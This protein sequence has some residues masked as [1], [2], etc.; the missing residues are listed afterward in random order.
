VTNCTKKATL[1]NHYA[2]IDE[3]EL[4][5][6]IREAV[7]FTRAI[8]IS[9]LWVDALCIIQ[10]DIHDW[11]AE[12]LNMSNIYEQST[13]TLAAS[14]ARDCHGGLFVKRDT[15]IINVKGEPDT[16]LKSCKIGVSGR[17]YNIHIESRGTYYDGVP[18]SL[19]TRGWTMQEAALSHRMIMCTN[20]QLHWRCNKTYRTESGLLLPTTSTVYGSV[21]SISSGSTLEIPVT[22][23]KLI[24]SYSTRK[25]TIPEDR[26]PAILGISR[27]WEG[28]TGD[29]NL[30]GLWKGTLPQDLLWMRIMNLSRS[31]L[32]D[33]LQALPSW[34]WLSCPVGIEY[35]YFGGMMREWEVTD[36]VKLHAHDVYWSKGPYLSQISRAQLTISGPV[37][38]IYLSNPAKGT[39]SNPPYLSTTLDIP[40]FTS[41]LPSSCAAQ[42][43]REEQ[44]PPGT[45][46]CMLVRTRRALDSRMGFETFLILESV[47]KDKKYIRVRRSGLIRLSRPSGRKDKVAI[48]SFRRIGLGAF[49]GTVDCFDWDKRMTIDLV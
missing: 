8:G 4:P 24:T 10:D 32:P 44:R 40:D 18:S 31:P 46:L 16:H 13:L 3:K 33:Y 20:E 12:I 47:E 49:R 14:E 42:F 28:I 27:Y 15:S 21:P 17:V 1:S 25:F 9:Y 39:D 36:H 48:D 22:W 29:K 45:F 43:D 11:Q 41:N 7:S 19:H 30:V 5:L 38:Q 26:L 34:T 35:D 6:T 23:W 2:A 37:M